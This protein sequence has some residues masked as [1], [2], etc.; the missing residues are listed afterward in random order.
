[1]T[2]AHRRPDLGKALHR[3]P[4]LGKALHRRPDLG[5]ALHRKHGREGRIGCTTLPRSMMASPRQVV[6]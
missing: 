5:K 2:P 6:R 4:D 3:R 1:M